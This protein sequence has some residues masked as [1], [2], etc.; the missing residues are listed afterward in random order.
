MW[1]QITRV[2]RQMVKTQI[3]PSEKKKNKPCLQKKGG[4]WKFLKLKENK[5]NA[6]QNLRDSAKAVLKRK[7]FSLP[8][9]SIRQTCFKKAK[10]LLD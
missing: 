2:H 4:G 6:Y 10:H 1:F 9:C 3:N 7:I 8:F 5:N